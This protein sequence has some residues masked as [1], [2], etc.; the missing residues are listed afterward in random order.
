MSEISLSGIDLYI[1]GS[2]SAISGFIAGLLFKRVSSNNSSNKS[3][4]ECGTH[5]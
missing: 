4:K 1:Y 2:M 3:K 5:G